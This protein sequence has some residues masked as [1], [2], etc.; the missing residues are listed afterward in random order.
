[1]VLDPIPAESK[2][3]REVTASDTVHSEPALIVL[4]TPLCWLRGKGN[5]QP[6]PPPKNREGRTR[7][8]QECPSLG[9]GGVLLVG[10]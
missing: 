6:D 4:C 2:E 8:Q 5:P 7:G 9:P 1:M 10:G 3:S